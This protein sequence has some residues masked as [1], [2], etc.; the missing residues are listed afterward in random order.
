MLVVTGNLIHRIDNDEFDFLNTLE[1]DEAK[2][3]KELEEQEEE[4]LKKFR[5]YVACFCSTMDSVI[6]SRRES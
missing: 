6:V 5:Q 1:N 4:E 3:K 2:K